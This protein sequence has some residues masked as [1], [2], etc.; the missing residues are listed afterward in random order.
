MG[1]KKKADFQGRGIE[2]QRE[3]EETATLAGRPIRRVL[4]TEWSS[5]VGEASPAR[6]AKKDKR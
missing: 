1:R 3:R 4:L 5:R 6:R 2:G